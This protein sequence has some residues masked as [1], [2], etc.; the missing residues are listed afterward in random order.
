M[1]LLLL[2]FFKVAQ[3]AHLLSVGPL[4]GLGEPLR[5]SRQKKWSGR[6]EAMLDFKR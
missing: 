2:N 4:R 5:D 6:V 1:L 3:L